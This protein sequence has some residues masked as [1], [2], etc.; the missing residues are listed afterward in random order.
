MQ[1][2]HAPGVHV[3]VLGDEHHA[4]GAAVKAVN[5]M[6]GGRAQIMSG[7]AC[8][9]DGFFCQCRAVNGDAGRFI[10]RQQM[11]IFPQNGE[12]VVHRY[13]GRRGGRVG[14]IHRQ[15]ITGV[16][17]GGKENRFTI[18]QYSVFTPEELAPQ[19]GGDAKTIPQQ[20]ADGMAFFRR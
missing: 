20:F 7:S 2:F 15:H 5:H 13:D 12:R 14:N 10:H 19:G 8:H 3:A 6:D 4:A 16:G 1:Q 18:E 9:G 17:A 11:L